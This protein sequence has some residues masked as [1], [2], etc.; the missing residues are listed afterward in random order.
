ML[1]D[2]TH[3]NNTSLLITR[4]SFEVGTFRCVKYVRN[5]QKTVLALKLSNHIFSENCYSSIDILTFDR[6]VR[7]DQKKVYEKY[8]SHKCVK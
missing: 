6:K 2:E 3:Q 5:A 4:R 7:V 1:F 8:A